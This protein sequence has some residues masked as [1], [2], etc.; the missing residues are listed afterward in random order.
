[1]QLV[2]TNIFTTGSKDIAQFQQRRVITAYTGKSVQ[3]ETKPQSAAAMQQSI[4]IETVY[5]LLHCKFLKDVGLR[6][7]ATHLKNV[8]LFMVVSTILKTKKLISIEA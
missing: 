5:Y 7:I 6:H 8:K 1:M 3:N 2:L 4:A